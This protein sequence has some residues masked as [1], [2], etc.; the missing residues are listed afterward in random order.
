MANFK[1]E[2]KDAV[3]SPEAR[4]NLTPEQ[5]ADL[6]R[7]L[8]EL[9]E[10]EVPTADIKSQKFDAKDM[11]PVASDGPV[12]WRLI[13]DPPPPPPPPPGKK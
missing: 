10:N 8:K 5:L 7:M 3:I 6:E 12:R 13:D 11:R 4:K 9:R 2:L 1:E